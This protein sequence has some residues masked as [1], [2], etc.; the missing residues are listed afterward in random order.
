MER[1]KST[2]FRYVL[3]GIVLFTAFFAK[4]MYFVKKEAEEAKQKEWEEQYAPSEEEYK[5]RIRKIA[6]DV[7]EESNT[8]SVSLQENDKSKKLK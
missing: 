3:F 7:I 2:T 1:I 4:D 8:D 6:L 5:A